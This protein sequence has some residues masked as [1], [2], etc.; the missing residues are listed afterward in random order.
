MRP[1]PQVAW[2]AQIDGVLLVG[3]AGRT[4]SLGYPAAAIWDLLV[5]QRPRARMVRMLSAIASL[6]ERTARRLVDEAI[7]QWLAAGLVVEVARGG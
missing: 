4:H 7:E 6:D 3:P 2:A 1:A 5:R